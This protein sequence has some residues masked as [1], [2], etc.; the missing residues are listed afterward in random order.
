ML[1]GCILELNGMALFASIGSRRLNTEQVQLLR[2]AARE[3]REKS[4]AFNT[5]AWAGYLETGSSM[6]LQI[7]GG[8]IVVPA[9]AVLP[10]AR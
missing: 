6:A 3:G 1:C 7:G 9:R 8:F 5:N 4:L 10:A 2:N